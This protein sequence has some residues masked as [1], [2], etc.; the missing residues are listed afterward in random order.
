MTEPLRK[1][2]I[3][4]LFLPSVAKLRSF[5]RRERHLVLSF[6]SWI[7]DSSKEQLIVRLKNTMPENFSIFDAGGRRYW[8]YV[9]IKQVISKLDIDNL[10]PKII[11]AAREFRK[12]SEWLAKEIAKLNN[13]PITEL[14]DKSEEIE[15]FPDGWK[16]YHHGQ[17][18]YCE[19]LDSLQVVEVPVWY[20]QEFG[21]L[22]PYFLSQFI[23]TTPSLSMPLGIN[24]WYHDMSRVM[25][26]MLEMG[27]LKKIQGT[28]FE[29]SGIIVT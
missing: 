28:R 20:G 12:Q 23:D 3:S 19:N 9:T 4:T 17:H 15:V 14:W 1:Y 8:S 16:C 27:L 13:V 29:V 21:V 22:D 24:D 11:H 7:S 2:Y 5:V 25:D 26:V 18:F 6:P 10:I